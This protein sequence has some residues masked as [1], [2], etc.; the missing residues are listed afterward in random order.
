[1]DGVGK[2]SYWVTMPLSKHEEKE[3]WENIVE[4]YCNENFL[5]IKAKNNSVE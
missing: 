1:M 3:V 5:T 4:L 2:N